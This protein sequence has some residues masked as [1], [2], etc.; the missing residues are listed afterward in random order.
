MARFATVRLVVHKFLTAVFGLGGGRAI[1]SPHALERRPNEPTGS[2]KWLSSLVA[3]SGF[4]IA[5][6]VGLLVLAG[7]LVG[8]PVGLAP[9]PAQ[10]STGWCTVLGAGNGACFSDPNS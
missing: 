8:L 1:G 10:A 3:L 5:G 2:G 9:T 7:M 6:K 4:G